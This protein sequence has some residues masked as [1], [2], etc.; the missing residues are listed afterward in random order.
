MRRP[1]N[2]AELLV[3]VLGE[4]GIPMVFG[5]PGTQTV[6]LFEALRTAPIRTVLATSELAASFMAGG[7]ARV[8]GKPGVVITIP[9]PGFTWALTG[10]A[11]ARLDSIPL[12]HICGAPPA[13]PG[14]R[15][16]Q[17]EL[18]QPAVAAPLTKATLRAAD[19]G[20]IP[21]LVRQGLELAQAGE[22]GPV[23]LEI[24]GELLDRRSTVPR[25]GEPAPPA[26]S[27]PQAGTLRGAS[28][29]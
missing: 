4:S 5:V 3:Q 18:D 7:L 23:L 8:T 25:P 20:A 21:A 11:E 14:R 24:P 9:G 10:I 1:S 13:T 26:Q 6:P 17:Q 16:R 27:Q 15:Y 29:D 12:L 28:R 2:G 19:A 22:P